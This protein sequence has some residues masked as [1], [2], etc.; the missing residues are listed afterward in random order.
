MAEYGNLNTNVTADKTKVELRETFRKWGIGRDHFEIFPPEDRWKPEA[1]VVYWKDG[2][3]QTMACKRFDNYYTNLRAVYL[4]LESLRLADQRG[5]L[6]ELAAAAAALL[7]PPKTKR[8]PNE[9]LGI[10][11]DTPLAEAE[12]MY[13][14]KAKR[15]H[16]DHG[17]DPEA[18]KELNE[19][20]EEYRK[21]AK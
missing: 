15:L 13:R 9:V 8:P 18:M 4:A 16:P 5:I 17:G 19:A 6:P 10:F 12:A 2:S 3:K 14:A 1:V 20:W 21:G 7:P 11:P